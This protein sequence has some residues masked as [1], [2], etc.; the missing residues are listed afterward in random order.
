[1]AGTI[2]NFSR[3]EGIL[4]L[5]GGLTAHNLRDFAS[6]APDTA[7]P[8]HKAFD[9]AILEAVSISDVRR[10]WCFSVAETYM[11]LTIRLLSARK[12]SRTYPSIQAS[13]RRNLVRSISFHCMSQ[14]GQEKTGV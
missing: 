1:M 10:P 13:V 6:F 9:S 5:S 11:F 8:L 7:K 14:R 4:V 2:A 3:E 12:R